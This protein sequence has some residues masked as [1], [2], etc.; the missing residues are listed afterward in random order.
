MNWPP[1]WTKPTRVW[2]PMNEDNTQSYWEPVELKSLT[3]PEY[4]ERTARGTIKKMYGALYILRT[5]PRS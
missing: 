1:H 2:E 4:I 3:L 5:I